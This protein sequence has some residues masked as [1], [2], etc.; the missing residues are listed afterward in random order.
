VIAELP[1][2]WRNRYFERQESAECGR[3]ALNNLMGG[4]QFLREDME[5]AAR[6]VLAVGEQAR[7]HIGAGGWYSHSV[8][9]GC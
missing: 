7:D 2:R 8:L 3:H 5:G 1:Q 4:S 9:G 6:E